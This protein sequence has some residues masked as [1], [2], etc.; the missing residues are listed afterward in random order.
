MPI[1]K[2]RAGWIRVMIV[3]AYICVVIDVALDIEL[4]NSPLNC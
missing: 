2:G 3:Y 1:N 4:V